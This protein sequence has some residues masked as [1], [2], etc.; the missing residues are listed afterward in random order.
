VSVII[1]SMKRTFVI[2]FV[3]PLAFFAIAGFFVLSENSIN[4]RDVEAN[5][6]VELGLLELS[7][8]G[9][10]G[11]YAMPASGASEASANCTLTFAQNPIAANGSTNITANINYTGGDYNHSGGFSV[12]VSNTNFKLTELG[13]TSVVLHDA[14]GTATGNT[15]TMTVP[16][17]SP[18]N[19]SNQYLYTGEIYWRERQLPT[20][21]G[22]CD[23]KNYACS[24]YHYHSDADADKIY[25]ATCTGVLTEGNIIN[26]APTVYMMHRINGGSYTTGNATINTG[27]QVNLI[28]S[29][30]NATLC[31]ASANPADPQFDAA[32]VPFNNASDNTITEPTGGNSTDFTINC[33]GP[34][35]NASAV[36][37]VTNTSPIGPTPTALT[38]VLEVCEG[39][40]NTNCK[41]VPVNT[42]VPSG[43]SNLSVISQDL[44]IRWT[45]NDV[46]ECS[47]SFY[48]SPTIDTTN[49]GYPS[50][51]VNV[52][53]PASGLSTDYVMNYCRDT[54]SGASV[55][56]VTISV[57]NN[58]AVGST[59]CPNF[60]LTPLPKVIRKGGSS[61][62]TWTN[63]SDS[64][65]CVLKNQAGT[66]IGSSGV[67]GCGD[68]HS[69]TVNGITNTSV[70][71]LECDDMTTRQARVQVVPTLDD[72]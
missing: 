22:Y 2:R 65:I 20:Y 19:A 39:P 4:S 1:V 59:L 3:V 58:S 62:L 69:V 71:T 46:N 11:G 64:S 33:T 28:W 34:G 35:G 38:A 55:G 23:P 54:V 57:T 24:E 63:S 25:R 41:S 32:S 47:F 16:S 40:A 66:V 44:N 60:N 70:Y 14:G 8:K 36:T 45:S 21:V 56:P 50:A 30:Y 27:D 61:V 67:S 6:S 5:S 48:P 53:G 72:N 17:A 15:L 26:P 29:A 7:P 68:S 52:V 42:S 10:A 49:P 18:P 43:S 51:R 31:S 13:A 9:E 12:D 37:T